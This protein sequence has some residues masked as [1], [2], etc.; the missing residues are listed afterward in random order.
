MSRVFPFFTTSW[1]K[2]LLVP[3]L[4]KRRLMFFFLIDEQLKGA[5]LLC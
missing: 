3:A 5:Q 4:K 2:I 1:L